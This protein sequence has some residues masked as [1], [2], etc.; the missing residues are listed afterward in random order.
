MENKKYT[1]HSQQN[2]IP[3]AGRTQHENSARKVIYFH[4]KKSAHLLIFS[5]FFFIFLELWW[6]AGPGIRR[7]IPPLS[8]DSQFVYR[9]FIVTQRQSLEETHR[10]E[11]ERSFFMKRK[12][13][14]KVLMCFQLKFIQFIFMF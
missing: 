7:P 12:R 3:P 4:K 8:S 1:D 13:R 2:C 6:Y 5:F 11:E 14:E 9:L 10:A